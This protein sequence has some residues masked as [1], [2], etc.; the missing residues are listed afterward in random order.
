MLC[1]CVRRAVRRDGGTDGLGFFVG[2]CAALSDWLSC[3]P[4]AVGTQTKA[5]DR[6]SV[7][8]FI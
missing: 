3:W 7:L 6:I 1:P 4:E 8:E 2:R 5:A